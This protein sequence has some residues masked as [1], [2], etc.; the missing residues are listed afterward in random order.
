MQIKD[1]LQA[2]GRFAGINRKCQLKPVRWVHGSGQESDSCEPDTCSGGQESGAHSRLSCAQLVLKWGGVLTHAGRQQAKAFGAFC[3]DHLYPGEKGGLLRLHSTFRHDLKIT[4]SD[5]GRV[6]ET[7]AAFSMGFLDLEGDVTRDLGPILISLVR[8]NDGPLLD[9]AG[10]ETAAHARQES[11]AAVHAM[12]TKAQNLSS[13][14]GV[15]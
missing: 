15:S 8:H 7:A 3:R 13:D 5:E 6:Q 9:D 12:L 2:G 11:K 1:V 10:N 14:P 4:T